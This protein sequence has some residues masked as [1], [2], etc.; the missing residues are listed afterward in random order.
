M[1]ENSKCRTQCNQYTCHRLDHIGNCRRIDIG[2]CVVRKKSKKATKEIHKFH[3][4]SKY[5]F[6]F[7]SLPILINN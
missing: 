4:L 3:Y 2:M 1:T 5:F 7:V 6:H